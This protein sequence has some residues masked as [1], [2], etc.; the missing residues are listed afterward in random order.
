MSNQQRKR[1]SPSLLACCRTR[2]G[3]P[4]N[5]QQIYATCPLSRSSSTS[6]LQYSRYRHRPNSPGAAG[7]EHTEANA[8]HLLYPNPLKLLI[9]NLLTRNNEQ[10]SRSRSFCKAD[11]CNPFP[12]TFRSEIR[13]NLFSFR[14]KFYVTGK[15]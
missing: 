6:V 13:P 9:H 4:A 15:V 14:P 7:F 10:R 1:S 3:Q 5:E 8:A 2:P 12:T 11:I